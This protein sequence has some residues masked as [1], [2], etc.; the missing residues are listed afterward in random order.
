MKMCSH[1]CGGGKDDPLESTLVHRFAIICA[2]ITYI[3]CIEFKIEI[4]ELAESQLSKKKMIF[5][6]LF[7]S[8]FG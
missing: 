1:D 8:S 4:V 5:I 2:A 3:I 6:F 7:A